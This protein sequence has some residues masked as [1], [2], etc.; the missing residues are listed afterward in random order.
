[1]ADVSNYEATFGVVDK[2]GDGFISAEEVRSLMK[3]LGKEIDDAQAQAFV[4]K[5]D[6]NG[7]GLISLEEFATVMEQGVD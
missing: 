7:D 3:T 1:M 2:D 4:E 6:G 5:A